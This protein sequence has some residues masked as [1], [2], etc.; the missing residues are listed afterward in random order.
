MTK[1]CVLD[2]E[3]ES[4]DP[5][6]GRIICI[7]IKDID[8]DKSIVFHHED[9]KQLL[10][11][12]L[13]YFHYKGFDE[14]I[15]Y[16]ILFDIRF[17]FGK[18]LKYGLTSNS[19][20]STK[21]TDLMHIMKSVKPVWSMNKPGTLNEWSEFLFGAGKFPLSESVKEK[22]EKGK[23]SEIIEYNKRDVELTCLLWKRIQKVFDNGNRM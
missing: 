2:I 1:R 19:F 21:H 4:L 23:I 9:E 22:F 3:T 16:N 13:E 17:I 20:F 11:D 15:G 6:E 10:K 18:C 5:K 8:S 7:G 12:F 14:I